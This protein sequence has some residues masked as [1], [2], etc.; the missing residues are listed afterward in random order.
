MA[1]EIHWFRWAWWVVCSIG[2]CSH[3]GCVARPE[4]ELVLYSAADREYAAPIL[5]AFAR[6][7]PGVSVA[8]VYDIESSKTVGLVNRIEN[9]AGQPKCDLFWNNEILHTIRLEQAGLLQPLS[10]IIPAD[11]PKSMR[12]ASSQWIGFAARA[13]VL[14]VNR[15][16]LPD[17]TQWPR[18]VMELADPKWNQQ[19]AVALPL[20]GTTATHFAVL[21][22]KLGSEAASNWFRQV[23]QN[24]TVLSGN[25][26]VAQAVAAG[27]VLFGLTDTD[28][29]I[30]EIDSGM[31]VAMVFPDQQSDDLGTLLIPN[32]LSIPKGCAH[33]AA[34]KTLAAYL[35]S[36]DIEG[37]LA[38]G[39]SGQIPI[40]PGHP[41]KSRA[42]P[43]DNL[44]KMEVDYAEVA[45]RWSA[46]STLLR[47]IFRGE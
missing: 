20:F 46:T 18:S 2:V 31:P 5:A 36:E 47:T 30:L 13:R 32:T 4:G 7:T 10:G 35:L 43:P 25:K 34:A 38:M 26:Q 23:K 29:A 17:S 37:R 27:H 40:R 22:A 21:E 39:P 28:D 6:K 15:D 9:E 3:L 1:P 14:L 41:Q 19:C 33:P 12:G 24:A 44:R 16:K 45:G 42:A 11:W 8:P